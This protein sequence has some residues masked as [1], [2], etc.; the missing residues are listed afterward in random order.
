MI[1]VGN[2]QRLKEDVKMGQ[3]LKFNYPVAKK[4]SLS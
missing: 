2:D 4:F 1:I 3:L